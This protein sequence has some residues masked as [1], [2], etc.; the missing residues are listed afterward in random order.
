MIAKTPAPPY[1][2]VIFSSLRTEGDLGYGEAA[3]RMLELAQQQP[4][5]LGV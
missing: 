1:Y 3:A 4:G 2:A 5:F